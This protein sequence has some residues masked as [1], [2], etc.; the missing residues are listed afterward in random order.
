MLYHECRYCTRRHLSRNNNI[1][2]GRFYHDC[3]KWSNNKENIVAIPAWKTRREIYSRQVFWFYIVQFHRYIKAKCAFYFCT[4]ILTLEP[5]SKSSGDSFDSPQNDNAANAARSIAS[6]NQ[7]KNF[8]TKSDSK[9]VDDGS[10]FE[11]V[12][13]QPFDIKCPKGQGIKS[14]NVKKVNQNSLSDAVIGLKCGP[15]PGNVDTVKI[16]KTLSWTVTVSL[17]LYFL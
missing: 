17:V 7:K 6:F 4:R 16:T 3:S 15:L 14:I 2:H 5:S 13:F 8:R 11:T 1:C 10:F 9:N 12:A